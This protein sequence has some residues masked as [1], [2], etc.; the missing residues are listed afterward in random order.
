M[1]NFTDF[2]SDSWIQGSSDLCEE[3]TNHWLYFIFAGYV[4]PLISPRVRDWFKETLNTLKNNEITGQIVTLTEYGFDKIQEIENNKEMKNYIKRLCKSK[5][6]DIYYSDESIEKMAWL[7][8]GESN[9][10]QEGIQQSWKKLNKLINNSEFGLKV[11]R[12]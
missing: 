6:P 12:P 10:G 2:S 9:N 5:N 4:L 1:D 11:V 7:F 3:V 8:S